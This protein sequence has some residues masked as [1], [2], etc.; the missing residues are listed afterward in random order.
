MTYRVSVYC[1]NHDHDTFDMRDV[2]K[3]RMT[4]C[5]QYRHVLDEVRRLSNHD[6]YGAFS[7]RIHIYKYLYNTY[8]S[9][10]SFNVRCSILRPQNVCKPL[11]AG[12]H[13]GFFSIHCGK[14]SRKHFCFKLVNLYL[15]FEMQ[16]RVWRD[17]KQLSPNKSKFSYENFKASRCRNVL[18]DSVKIVT[19]QLLRQARGNIIRSFRGYWKH[20][21][22][23]LVSQCR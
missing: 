14:K 19:L 3:S 18:H 1:S 6:I 17:C 4:T 20:L 21:N 22:D 12:V 23:I 11:L 5:K 2:C 10:T 16:N 7:E 8:I 13:N 9:W 15:L